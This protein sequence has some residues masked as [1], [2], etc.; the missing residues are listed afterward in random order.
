VVLPSAALPL[1]F[2][3]TG[4]SDGGEGEGEGE[5]TIPMCDVEDVSVLLPEVAGSRPDAG[6]DVDLTCIGSPEQVGPGT[7]ATVEGCVEVFGLGDGVYADTRVAY[8]SRD[9]NPGTDTPAYGEVTVSRPADG[10]A[11]DCDGADE[12]APACLARDC[13]DLGYY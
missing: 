5:S 3:C 12:N 9:Q 2:A 4:P 7:T 6:G 8:C 10:A 13:G 11:L 1:L